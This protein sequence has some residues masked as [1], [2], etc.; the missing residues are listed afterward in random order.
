MLPLRRLYTNSNSRKHLLGEDENYVQ[1][2]NNKVLK[3]Q[4]V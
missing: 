2:S 3:K 4:T 1:R